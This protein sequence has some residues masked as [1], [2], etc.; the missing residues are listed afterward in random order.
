MRYC[1]AKSRSNCA[2]IEGQEIRLH[3]LFT[4]TT[5][6][7]MVLLN[8]DSAGAKKDQVMWDS[9]LFYVYSI[10][11]TMTTRGGHAR[12]NEI[13]RGNCKV[14]YEHKKRF[15]LNQCLLFWDC[16]SL[17]GWQQLL[18]MLRV[19][20]LL[21][22]RICI[23]QGFLLWRQSLLTLVLSSCFYDLIWGFKRM[24][25]VYVHFQKKIM[26]RNPFPS[27]SIDRA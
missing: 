17:P 4:R 26:D 23:G 14:R 6:K 5:F 8:E 19:V 20:S 3:F 2:A 11:I 13:T 1:I 22:L 15:L 27:K 16:A 21:L 18:L 24:S 25:C 10:K 9:V 12:L 7:E